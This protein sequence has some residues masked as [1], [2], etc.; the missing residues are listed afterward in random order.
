MN[1]PVA[2]EQP[3]V[4]K[5][6]DEFERLR[7]FHR[8]A[9]RLRG[10][11]SLKDKTLERELLQKTDEQIVAYFMAQ[12]EFGDYALDF[13]L[14][15]LGFPRDRL[16]LQNGEVHPVVFEFPS[17]ISAAREVLRDG[18]FL[19]LIELEQP[20]YHPRLYSPAPLE[21]QKL[22]DEERRA[23]LFANVQEGLR[24][25]IRAQE[26][27]QKPSF[28]AS[29][30]AFLNDV[31]EGGQIADLGINYLFV[32]VV[33]NSNIWYGR[34]YEICIGSLP[35][36][37][38]D[39]L[40]ELKRIYITNTKVWEALKAFEP[41][42]YSTKRLTS[43]KALDVKQL[44]VA[45]RWHLFGDNHRQTLMN[46]STNFNRKRAAYVLK[47]FFCDDLT[48]ITVENP[49]EHTGRHGSEASC[50]SC[51]YKLDPMAGFFRDYGFLF[52]HY[53]DS[54]WIRFDDNATIEREEYHRA[55]LA[56]KGAGR[57]WDIG[58]IRSATK[59]ELN[60]Y[61]DTL[62]DLFATIRTEP[63]VKSCMMK[64][65][66][67]Y[68]LGEK[69]AVDAGY[70]DYLAKQFNTQ[71]AKNSTTAFKEATK[72]ILL[73]R[74]F[75]TEDPDSSVY[76]DFPPNYDPVGRPPGRVAF[77]FEKNCVSCHSSTSGNGHLD[78]RS[79]VKLSDEVFSFSHLSNGKQLPKR[80]TFRRLSDRLTT[81]DSNRR[82]PL[83]QH[84]EPLDREV[85]FR[86]INEYLDS[87]EP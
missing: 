65:L 87:E 86:W 69:Q 68:H 9:R 45:P 60:S 79:W 20:L 70:M 10:G 61:G 4:E 15:F 85:L 1:P 74:A 17:A 72:R 80:E 3:V 28:A 71:A 57:T 82:M 84:M 19:K 33:F 75:R 23:V 8:V 21:G 5:P 12:P 44:G 56:P 50:M 38:V 2:E 11:Q 77:L 34:L 7:W 81:S 13:S 66:F 29:C 78:L 30:E 59:P 36:D 41:V 83:R 49:G 32:D 67:A 22:G 53:T 6:T 76:Y 26:K 73:S 31:R 16:R 63:E 42:R 39:F 51:H 62:D 40:A 14:H 37:D 48:P 47:T 55:W 54:K 35:K 64:R 58:F 24:R 46:S 43:I 27:R 25:Q 52:G 18:D